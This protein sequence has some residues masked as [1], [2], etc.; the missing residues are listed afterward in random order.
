MGE[1]GG[2]LDE[3]ERICVIFEEDEEREREEGAGIRDATSTVLQ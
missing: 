1:R 2:A 3:K